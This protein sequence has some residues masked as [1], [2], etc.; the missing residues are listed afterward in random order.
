M[1]ND[2]LN[3]YLRSFNIHVH[4]IAPSGGTLPYKLHG[5]IGA[6]KSV[7]HGHSLGGFRD[8][9]Y[10][11]GCNP[12]APNITHFLQECEKTMAANKWWGNH[13]LYHVLR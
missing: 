9:T 1:H 7:E 6:I 5:Q 2:L 11:L 12:L 4:A 8:I 3:E 10:H 13:L